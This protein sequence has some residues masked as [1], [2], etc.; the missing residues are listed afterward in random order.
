MNRVATQSSAANS[1]ELGRPLQILM[2]EHSRPDA[3]LCLQV[4]KKAGFQVRVNLVQTPEEFV[5]RLGSSDYDIVLADYRLPQ[6]T[7]IEAL[8]LLKQS[9]KDIP[10]LLVTGTLGE[11]AAVECIKQGVTEYVLK[12]RLARLPVAVNRALEEKA[13]REARA[14]A[15]QALRL[16]EA[17]FR[18]LF[19]NNPLP[20]WVYDAESL[21]FLQV[22]DA[23]ISSYGYSRE[24]FLRMR[25]TDIR[26]PEDVPRLLEYLAKQKPALRSGGQWRHRRKDDRIIDVEIATHELEFAGRPAMLVVAQDIAERKR[27]V[28]A[29]RESEARYRELVKNATYGIYRTSPEGKFLDVNPALVT[30][31]SYSSEEEVLSLNLASDVY[32]NPVAPKRLLE[33]VAASDLIE[34]QEVEWKRKDGTPILVRLSG[35]LVRDAQGNMIYFEGIAEDVTERRAMERHLRQV[36]KFEA[37]GQ[38]AGGVAHDFNN[39]IGAILG[40]AELGMDQTPAESKLHTHF[41]KIREQADRAAAL[42]R[43]LLAFARRQILEPQEI[44]LNQAIGDLLN[45]LEKVIGKDVELKTVLAPDLG[46]IRADPS[47]LE[48]VLM[49]LCLNARDA[50]PRGGRLLIETKNLEIDEEYYRRHTYTRSGRYVVLSVSDNGVGIDSATLEHIFEPFFTT[51]GP[52]KG[53]GLG[54]ATVYGVVKQHGGFVH[55]YSEPGQG[56]TF[57]VYLPVSSGRPGKEV[58][59]EKQPAEAARGGTETILVAEDHEGVRELVRSALERLGYRVILASDG[60]E[61][62][63]MFEAHGNEIALVLIDVVMPKLSGQEAYARM[64]AGRPGLPV[65]FTTGYSSEPASLDALVRHGVAILQKPYHTAHLGQKVREVL[66]RADNAATKQANFP[67][68]SARHR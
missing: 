27:A 66:D 2:V 63:R 8:A 25:I 19:A 50:M 26:P 61:A 67:H 43:Q 6:W 5:E 17:S 41:W 48:Q 33:Q 9:G 14:R 30:M 11:E 3:E 22:N 52:G 15:E 21:H 56:A 29:L 44:N 10:F 37:I 54:L 64:S 23:A 38:L 35:R 1:Q 4:L 13:L 58:T 45:L 18:L 46:V 65:L 55:V 31:L 39:V 49:N 68:P 40:W 20:M 36:H 57:N 16:S 42:T 60:E 28:E 32:V 24:E 62:V 59:K 53:T 34:G 7:G 47:Q 51:K 12:D